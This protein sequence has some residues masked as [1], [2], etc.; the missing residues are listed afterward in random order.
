[1]N[2]DRTSDRQLI[3]NRASQRHSTKRLAYIRADRKL[4]FVKMRDV[5]HGGASFEGLG[6][7]TLGQDLAYCVGDSE[8]ILARVKWCDGDKFGVQNV[9]EWIDDLTFASSKPHR[10]LRLPVRAAVRLFYFGCYFDGL[11]RN[12]SQTGACIDA[13]IFFQPGEILDLQ[14]GNVSIEGAEVQWTEG[15]HTGIRFAQT[16]ERETISQ[17]LSQLQCRRLTVHSP[18]E[19]AT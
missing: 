11:L 14:I 5:S 18:G 6:D 3:E 12:L 10:A 8:P 13:D 1:M 9:V 7:L 4:Y 16:I 19:I 17:A 15:T 2:S